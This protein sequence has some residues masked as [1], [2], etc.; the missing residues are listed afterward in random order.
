MP[1]RRRTH[2][3]TGDAALVDGDD[4]HD[5]PAIDVAAELAKVAYRSLARRDRSRVEMQRLLASHCSDADVVDRV[6]NQLQ[7]RGWLSEARMAGQFVDTRRARMGAQRLR[8]E[9]ARRGL[10]PEVIAQS[11]AGL[12]RTDLEI[13]TALWQKRFHEPAADRKEQER[14]LRF[15]LTRGF[16]RAVALKVLRAGGKRE[17]SEDE[18]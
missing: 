2:A 6:L 9:M 1:A 18:E 3:R 16:N 7:S 5:D 17:E 12:E 14:Q 11:T 8:Q 15:L 4:V 10:A 13:A